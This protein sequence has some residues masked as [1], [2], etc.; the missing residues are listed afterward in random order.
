M[1]GKSEVDILKG[2]S[3]EL[4]KTT[5]LTQEQKKDIRDLEKICQEND[6][7][8]GNIFLSNEINFNKE[9]NCFL[10][11]YDEQTLISF[12]AM[13]I[14]TAQ[15]AEISAYTLPSRRRQGYFG[16]LLREAIKELSSYS[17]HSILF[18]QE[19]ASMD[20]KHVLDRLGAKYEYSEYLL[21]YNAQRRPINTSGKIKLLQYSNG[22]I[23][24]IVALNV[25]IFEEDR[26]DSFS[27]VK[28]S[29]ESKDINTYIAYLNDEIIGTCNVN[30]ESPDVSIF[31]L[32]ISSRYQGHGYGRE[33]LNLLLER[34]LE[35]ELSSITLE[36]NSENNRAYQLYRN[37]GFDIKTQF[38][39]YRK[40]I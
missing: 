17:I 21:V 7:L 29:L 13:F 37:N 3:M 40:D 4:I 20:G 19:P 22:S 24:D 9:I 39:Y 32:G 14:P 38:D 30:F 10:M 6:H 1:N 31:G 11:L 12:L 15:E 25:D 2:V 35:M 34:L 26:E 18:V 5:F 8:K 23:E 28:K 36:V 33:M 27:M 16:T